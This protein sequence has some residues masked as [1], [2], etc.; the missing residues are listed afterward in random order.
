MI[1][2]EIKIFFQNVWKNNLLTN[3][4]LEVQ[5]EFDTIFIQKPL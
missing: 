5:K 4:I 3:T 2:K 1:I